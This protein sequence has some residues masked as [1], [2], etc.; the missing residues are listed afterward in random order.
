M[1]DF[2]VRD[3]SREELHAACVDNHL[4]WLRRM[5]EASGG[6]V[7][8]TG[9]LEW[10]VTRQPMPE[11]TVAVLGP[12]QP[13]M[14]DQIDEIVAYC[15]TEGIER[16]SFWTA[17]DAY[18]SRLWPWLEARGLRGGEQPR[19]M[20]VDLWSLPEPPTAEVLAKTMDVTMPTRF[21]DFTVPELMCFGPDT[22]RG[23]QEMVARWPDHV[24]HG[25]LWQDGVPVGQLSFNATEGELGVIGLHNFLILPGARER[26]PGLDRFAWVTRFSL[27]RGC[28]YLVANALERAVPLY[29]MMN[30]HEVGTGQTWWATRD[31]FGHRPADG[32][33]LLAESIGF[34]D[35]DGVRAATAGWGGE[36]LDRPLPNGMTPLRFAGRCRNP[37]AARWLLSQGA[38]ADLLAAWD[39]GWRDEAGRLLARDPGTALGRRPRSGKTLLHVAVERNDPDLV[40]LLLA[41]GADLDARDSR[42]GSTPLD[43]AI[44]L[45][46]RRVAAM[47][48]EQGTGPGMARPG[49]SLEAEGHGA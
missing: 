18:V 39:L 21:D 37:D 34:G 47:L 8:A 41:A 38:T 14:R 12:P 46:R 10:A 49:P 26:G 15:R 5:T 31:G 32:Q 30:F 42:Y 22:W 25:V 44:V 24:W 11:A 20:A 36:Q 23:R 19:W 48:R 6:H 27:D 40:R 29:Q 9:L 43:W 13:G 16:L 7:H 45:R 17:D 33:V 35:L 2:L 1:M 28:R 3:A 4:V